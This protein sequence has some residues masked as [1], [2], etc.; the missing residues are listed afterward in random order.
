VFP[1]ATATR[2]VVS[3]DVGIVIVMSAQSARAARALSN[4]TE[5]AACERSAVDDARFATESRRA[6]DDDCTSRAAR[7]SAVSFIVA[8]AAS[9]SFGEP[10]VRSSQSPGQ[11]NEMNAPLAMMSASGIAA[12]K[13]SALCQLKSRTRPWPFIEGSVVAFSRARVHRRGHH[14]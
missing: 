8:I 2:T 6:G 4:Q 7:S 10:S 14:K 5:S 11:R 12:Q 9:R 13:P 1:S 3:C